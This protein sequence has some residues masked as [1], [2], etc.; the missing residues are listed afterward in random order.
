M[1][2][3]IR[4]IALGALVLALGLPQ[5][6]QAACS[7]TLTVA[8]SP[9]GFSLYRQRDGSLAGVVVDITRELTRRSGCE[10]RLVER[11]RARAVLEF[12]NGQLDMLTSAVRSPERDAFAHYVHYS[13]TQLDLVLAPGIQASNMADFT[14]RG[15]QA[16]LGYVRGTFLGEEFKARLA[17]LREAR[18]AD[19]ASDY[20]NLL[21]R[22]IAGRIQAALIPSLIHE[23]MRQTGELSRRAAHRAGQRL[24]AAADRHLF[25]HPDGGRRGH[26]PHRSAAARDAGG[27][28]HRAPLHAPHRRRR[29]CPAVSSRRADPPLSGRAPAPLNA[30]LNDVALRAKWQSRLS[31]PPVS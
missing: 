3:S 19:E 12:E 10:F 23:R 30:G 31:S 18:R 20:D 22:L 25:P 14:R 13:Y 2:S 8:V 28:Q 24:A 15:G 29:S 27:R 21:Q 1:S 4:V 26:R 11:P 5:G 9:L 17:P 16:R 6:V 7:K